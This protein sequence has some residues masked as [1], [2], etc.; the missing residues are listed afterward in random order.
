[1]SSV[2]L[3]DQ[4]KPADAGA[5][6]IATTRKKQTL[7]TL[8]E[9]G[10]HRAELETPKLLRISGQLSSLGSVASI[11]TSLISVCDEQ[12]ALRGSRRSTGELRARH[13]FRFVDKSQEHKTLRI[14]S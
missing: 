5:H 1:M 3:A 2:K 7:D 6:I 12:P 10:A 13:F 11:R 4:S 14:V 8:L 9:L